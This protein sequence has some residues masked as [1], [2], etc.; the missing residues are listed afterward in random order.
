[1]L[2]INI[3]NDS[4][5]EG[6]ETV[7]LTL[8]NS[9]T[10]SVG[11]SSTGTIDIA[12]KP[13][14][15]FN[16]QFDYR[17]D[18]N[19][20][21]TAEKIAAL[22]AAASIWESIIQDEFTDVASGTQFSV[23]NPQTGINS[24]VTLASP[25]DDLLIFVGA[26]SPPFADPNKSQA[27]GVAGPSGTD[28]EG[29]VFRNRYNGSNFE[30]WVGKLSFNTTTNWFFDY[31]PD[32]TNDIPYDQIDFITV[33]LHEIGHILGISTAPIFGMIGADGNFDGPNTLAA[34]GN[35]P[36]PLSS[37]GH[38]QDGYKSSGNSILMD[39]TISPGTRV[40]PT[41]VD[42]AML[43]D[44]GYQIAGFTA[45]GSTPP[46]ATANGEIIYGTVVN[47][48][49]DGLGGNDQIQGSSGD[50]TLQGNTG[51]DTLFGEAGNDQLFGGDNDDRL[52]GGAGN[53]L[54]DGGAGNDDMR[55]QGG[56]NIFSFGA[57]N[58]NDNIYDFVVA[59]D[60][61]RVAPGLGFTTGGQVFATLSKPYL[62]V[63]R[64]TLSPGNYI[65]VYHAS[66]D[67]TP[68]TEA[69]FVIA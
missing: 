69:N 6:N 51:N 30:P 47:D 27:A 64:F 4:L 62:N 42:K 56:N 53:D 65:D 24:T 49:I 50:D 2:P 34:N 14:N 8:N 66:M 36:V 63:S 39:P 18:T 35:A 5:V 28:V 48:V 37:D 1:M 15:S 57:S 26:A 41:A 31:T 68:L 10:Y 46:I 33:A 12:D 23:Q 16:I 19:G 13:A 61:I 60:L 9:S 38:V 25:I 54:L 3:I 20:W 11:N 52:Q 43:A 59:T 58:G 21:F 44:I 22:E 7:I 40:L 17:F 45:Q 55:G 32:T 67:G 29:S